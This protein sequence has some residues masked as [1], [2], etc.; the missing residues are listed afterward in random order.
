MPFKEKKDVK[1]FFKYPQ[2]LQTL[3]RQSRQNIKLTKMP[4]AFYDFF[5]G[6]FRILD[7]RGMRL[8]LERL[9]QNF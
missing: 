6:G 7:V 5:P 1:A 2:F 8:K 3:A 4:F 9:W